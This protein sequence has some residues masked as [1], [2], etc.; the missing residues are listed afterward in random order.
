MDALVIHDYPGVASYP[1]PSFWGKYSH[2]THWGQQDTAFP[3]TLLMPGMMSHTHIDATFPDWAEVDENT[4][5]NF[6]ITIKLFDTD[7]AISDAF[8]NVVGNNGRTQF[9]I[10]LPTWPIVGDPN[11]LIQV[12][13]SAQIDFKTARS[14]GVPLHGWFGI[15]IFV[16]TG[17]KVGARIDTEAW[18]PLFST[19]DVTSPE[20]SLIE[21]SIQLATKGSVASD[22]ESL[23]FNL[24]VMEL[25]R[26]DPSLIK[27]N[28]TQVI[29]PYGYGYQDPF[30]LQQYLMAVNAS[31]HD[32][33]AGVLQPTVFDGADGHGN[34]DTLKPAE[35][36]KI[37][38]PAALGLA[39]NQFSV[40]M[41]WF[42]NSG[43]GFIMKQGSP[44]AS[45]VRAGRQLGVLL[46]KTYTV[47][48]APDDSLP[49]T[50]WT[51]D[52]KPA[53]VVVPPIVIPPVVVPPVNV[54]ITVPDLTGMT[55]AQASA[56]LVT[57]GLVIGMAT[58]AV[59]PTVAAESIIS[60]IPLPEAMANKGDVVNVIVSLGSA[61][62][63]VMTY[64]GTFKASTKDGGMSLQ[65][66]AFE[67]KCD[68]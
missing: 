18:R 63:L 12:V 32:N 57:L 53:P 47:G 68:C 6:P 49:P 28:N 10:S 44:D 62:P 38:Q 2:Q 34:F 56:L 46:T 45:T 26:M 59:S 25:H 13:G 14:I 51:T 64:T 29:E 8:V 42:I 65:I 11:G 61:P 21:N 9:P 37:P 35:F 58:G 7:G 19:I 5:I 16:R 23:P 43:N 48:D 52:A 41:G 54:M 31:L 50:L 30:P 40:L 39:S 22:T 4:V 1:D 17:L 67:A 36:L 20:S 27:F 15:Q 60:Q 33:I 24:Q 66:D 3:L 55:Q